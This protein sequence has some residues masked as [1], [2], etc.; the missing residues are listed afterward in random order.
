[1]KKEKLLSIIIPV[2]NAE[3]YLSECL[4]S[5]FNIKDK[6]YL[7]QI[8]VVIIDDGSADM[9]S[10]IYTDFQKKYLNIKVVKNENHG[11]SY[12]RN[13][14]ISIATGKYITFVDADDLLKENWNNIVTIDLLN[15]EYDLVFHSQYFCDNYADNLE[16]NEILSYILTYNKSNIRI[17][18]PYSKLFNRKFLLNNNIL[19]KEDLINGED[20]IF[21]IESLLSS[22]SQ[23][24]IKDSYYIVRHNSYSA[25]NNFNNKIINSEKMFNHYIE[26][27]FNDRREYNYDLIK[28]LS[29]LTSIRILSYRISFL[30]EYNIAK[31]KCKEIRKDPYFSDGLKNIKVKN[32]SRTNIFFYLFKYRLYFILYY[33]CRSKYA[34]NKEDS[35][36]IL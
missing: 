22:S 6:E 15:K 16:K 27:I 29:F 26:V 13:Y 1:M 10:Q 31:I 2:Y 8:E 28:E 9:S 17:S 35:F 7:E 19:F 24:L 34:N 25:T 30:K 33:L 21:N 4:T 32:K 12:T 5:I 36:E 3:K 14:G 20:M 11:V 18:G 23:L